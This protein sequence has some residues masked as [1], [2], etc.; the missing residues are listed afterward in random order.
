[1]LVHGP[2]DR[3]DDLAHAAGPELHTDPRT[4]RP[5]GLRDGMFPGAL[6]RTAHHNEIAV[7]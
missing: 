5:R 1:M 4:Y 7:T 3:C 2:Q 6:A